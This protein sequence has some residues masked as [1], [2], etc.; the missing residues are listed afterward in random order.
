MAHDP[1]LRTRILALGAAAD[2]TILARIAAIPGVAAAQ[3]DGD[4]RR[5]TLSYDIQRA[6]LGELEPLLRA[7][8]LVLSRRR[9]HRWSRA[10]A[11]FQDDNIRS[12]ARLRHQCCC[13]PPEQR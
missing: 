5:L 1:L 11:A 7:A 12:N 3:S 8:G 9:L 4:G 13:T 10:W 2:S 6:T